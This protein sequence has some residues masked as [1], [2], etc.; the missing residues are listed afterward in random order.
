M[1]MLELELHVI[2]DKIPHLL[3][4]LDGNTSHPFVKKT[5]I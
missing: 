4:A 1:S 2:I 3:N 5:P